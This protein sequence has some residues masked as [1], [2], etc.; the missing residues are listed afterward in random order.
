VL[1]LIV[2]LVDIGIEKWASNASGRRQRVT[3][4]LGGLVVRLLPTSEY[5]A[6]LAQRIPI[7]DLPFH[8]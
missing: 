5:R 7:V 8:L 4:S 6:R 1:S 2:R 3:D